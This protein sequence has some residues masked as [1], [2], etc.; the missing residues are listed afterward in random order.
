M[1][2]KKNGA[3][4]TPG[5]LA[6]FIMRYTADCFA[7]ANTLSLLEPSVGDGSFVRAFN[8]TNF[9]RSI[10][11]FSFTGVEKIKPELDKAF[12]SALETKK[13][14]TKYSFLWKDFLHYQE[15]VNK[16][17]SLIAG[18]PPYIK[19]TLLN[20]TQISICESIH[21]SA[22]L[23]KT[24]VKNIWSAF[25]IRCSQ[26][27]KENGVMALVLPADLLQVQFSSELRSYL[28]SIFQRLEIFTFDDLLFE[29]KGQDT[30]L[31][32]AYKQHA[33]SGQFYTH[34]TDVKQL[35]TN[36]F[37]LEQKQA[38]VATETKWIHH[39]LT[40][41]EINFLHQLKGQLK[42][43]NHYCDSKPGIVTAA[44]NFFIVDEATKKKYGLSA[45]AKPI[46]QKGFFVN[47]SVVFDNKE[48]EKLVI[49]GKPSKVLVFNDNDA[50]NL[51]LKVKEYLK[52][53][54]DL[55]LP[56]R[57]KCLLRTN[58]Y[59][60]PNIS[61]VPEG[62]FF[63]RS[64]R[65]PK[66]LKNEAQVLVTDSA[67]K[68]E[69]RTGYDINNLVYSFYNSL[70]LA[71]AELEGRYYGGG[72]LELTPSEFKKLPVPNIRISKSKFTTFTKEFKTKN[73][74]LDVLDYND[75]YILSN[76]L[77]LNSEEIDQVKKIYKKL[78]EKRFRNKL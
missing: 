33:F 27:L 35:E 59:V 18:N 3:Y 73:D 48:Y 65:Y 17:F 9:P 5:H 62:F 55:E 7:N 53:G 2:K 60:I 54:E 50:N 1:H 31:L 34:I 43:I 41:N 40:D 72:V 26:L 15:E 44:N 4:Y 38:M 70:T 37:V 16:K 30:I 14:A 66:L 51:S 10:K 21:T 64:H 32:F 11:N 58:W 13:T 75:E 67:Y 61:T 71:F 49:D 47:G 78:I 22:K 42:T 23:S 29:C 24:G 63:K 69:M 74:I 39:S 12:K 52:Y 28:T 68:I 36:N 77:N 25:V 76:A 6:D 46:I 57:Y 20:K 45:Y 19:K 56:T 8:K